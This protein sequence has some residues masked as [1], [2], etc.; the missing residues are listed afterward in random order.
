MD[1]DKKG[2]SPNKI[3]TLSTKFQ[4]LLNLITELAINDKHNIINYLN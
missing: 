4:D 3:Y 1:L 2:Q